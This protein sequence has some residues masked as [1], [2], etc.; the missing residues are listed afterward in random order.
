MKKFI[1]F[2][3][4]VIFVLAGCNQQQV[5]TPVPVV[6]PTAQIE[7]PTEPP[8]VETE[9]PTETMVPT[10]EP[11]E[12]AV[13]TEEPTEIPAEESTEIPDVCPTVGFN[14]GTPKDLMLDFGENGEKHA[15]EVA[16]STKT[17]IKGYSTLMHYFTKNDLKKLM[18]E[19]HLSF[20]MPSPG[21]VGGY[22]ALTI[23]VNNQLLDIGVEAKKFVAGMSAEGNFVV[24]AGATIDIEL[25]DPEALEDSQTPYMFL[26]IM[27]L[28]SEPIQMVDLSM[29]EMSSLI[30]CGELWEMDV[31]NTSNEVVSIP[32][33]TSHF[34]LVKDFEN[35]HS[36]TF[37][38][39]EVLGEDLQIGTLLLHE[40]TVNLKPGGRITFLVFNLYPVN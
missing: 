27:F 29:P 31:T 24:P 36:I 15:T 13:P 17:Y 30:K 25:N 28:P 32:M 18:S 23:K 11:T 22:K 38:K 9:E 26:F 12:T 16:V 2:L 6:E 5:V 19:G 33:E 34:L 4:I 10:E 1:S 14:V 21:F 7:Q 35:V 37:T 39:D 40:E 3:L 20:S 8:V